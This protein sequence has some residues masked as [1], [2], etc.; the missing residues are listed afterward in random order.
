MK[1]TRRLL[2]RLIKESARG[3]SRQINKIAQLLTSSTDVDTLTQYFEL[4]IGSGHGQP[5]SFDAIDLLGPPI[6]VSMTVSKD[7]FHAMN[8]FKT[9]HYFEIDP[10]T[11]MYKIS[12]S[13]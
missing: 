5:G 9:I 2:V 3:N 7:L 12:Y 11:R 8:R 1:I 4:A 6:V 13:I 10:M